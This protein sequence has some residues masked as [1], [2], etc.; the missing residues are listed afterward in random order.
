MRDKRRAKGCERGEPMLG[1]E[2]I[3]S[4]KLDQFSA[5]GDFL[6]QGMKKIETA[7][8]EAREQEE[9]G[10]AKNNEKTNEQLPCLWSLGE[11]IVTQADQH[12]GNRDQRDE[13]NDAVKQHREQCAKFFRRRFLEQEVRLDDVASSAAGQELIVKHSNKKK[14]GYARHAEIDL[15]HLEQNLPAN[16]G[17]NFDKDVRENRRNDPRIV[18]R[19]QRFTHLGALHGIVKDPVENCNRNNELQQREQDFFHPPKRAFQVTTERR[20]SSA[21]LRG[22]ISQTNK[23]LG[24]RSGT[25]FSKST[26]PANGGW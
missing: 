26:S 21:V 2:M 15:L 19:P 25:S 24:G 3:G 13:P 17:R 9:N 1:I 16:S 8:D 10:A 18:R 22:L 4:G 23:Q 6:R 11:K 5:T 12:A 7:D 14:A 20:I